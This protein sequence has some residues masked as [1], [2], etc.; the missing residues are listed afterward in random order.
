[1]DKI[2]FL[3]YKLILRGMVY[4]RKE[5]F[6]MD[7]TERTDINEFNEFERCNWHYK[8]V[9]TKDN[10]YLFQMKR[11]GISTYL[12]YEI[13]KG[14]PYTQPDGSKI[15]IKPCDEDFGKYGWYLSG[16]KDI[17]CSVLDRL[18]KSQGLDAEYFKQFIG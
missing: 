16:T 10:F 18:G 2:S 7:K 5:I 6:N 9:A 1:M 12:A 8:R 11:A 15:M 13:W 14:K 17:I 3:G 4:E